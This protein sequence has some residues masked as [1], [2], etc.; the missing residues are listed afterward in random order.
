M[1]TYYVVQTNPVEGR[2]DEYNDWYNSRHIP[3]VLAVAGFA[4]ARRYT[5]ADLPKNATAPYRYLALYEFE[6]DPAVALENLAEA[7]A[8][9]MLISDAMDQTPE[10][11]PRAYVYTPVA[12]RVVAADLAAGTA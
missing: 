1:T 6:G 8:G 10:R 3:D 11:G 7:V 9:G 2:E 4:A 12:D 5:L